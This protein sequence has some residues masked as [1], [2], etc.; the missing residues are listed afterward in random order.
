MEIKVTDFEKMEIILRR[1]CESSAMIIALLEQDLDDIT[2]IQTLS[3]M[4]CSHAH[5]S[6]QIN[7]RCKTDTG[8]WLSDIPENIKYYSNELEKL[9]FLSLEYTENSE[10]EF[11]EHFLEI[12]E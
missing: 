10:N 9:N 7:I 2:L 12:F 4:T 8:E 1:M 3:M 11:Y 6:N 5:F